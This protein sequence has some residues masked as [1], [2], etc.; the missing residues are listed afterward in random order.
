VTRPAGAGAAVTA[1]VIGGM[2]A[3]CGSTVAGVAVKAPGPVDSPGV[4]VALLDTGNYATHAGHPFGTAGNPQNGAYLDA[5]RM[6]AFVVGPWQVD[7]TLLQPV[8][9]NTYPIE[10]DKRLKNDIGAAAIDVAAGHGFIDGFTTARGQRG[11]GQQSLV[12]VKALVNLVMRFP[13]ADEATAAAEEMADKTL[14]AGDPLRRPASIPRH[15]E[16][17]A[18]AFDLRDGGVEVW[19]FAPHGPYVLW[20]AATSKDQPELAGELVAKTLDLQA[21][22]IDEFIPTDPAKLTDLPIDPTGRLLA[23]TLP[24]PGGNPPPNSGVWPSR[25]WLHFETNPAKAQKLFTAASVEVVATRGTTVVYQA[26]DAA[27][28]ARVVGTMSEHAK[29]KPTTAVPGLPAAK[30]VD[31]GPNAPILAFRFNCVADADRYAFTAHSEQEKD[32]KQ[33]ISAQYRILAGK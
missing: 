19:S 22:R 8:E 20:Q 17:A 18:S 27:G 12:N 21:P 9:F 14:Q 1:L 28:A 4:N 24:A 30:C 29:A 15:P 5:L 3:G 2:L 10:I 13:N 33:Q 32:V 16:A 23:R 26:N 6:A 25:G 11:Q 7:E 31:Q